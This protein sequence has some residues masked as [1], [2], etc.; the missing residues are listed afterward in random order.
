MKVFVTGGAGYIGSVCC[1]ELIN[2]GHSVVIFDNLSEGHRSAVDSR[3]EFIKGDLADRDLIFKAMHDARPDAVMHFAAHALVGESM[4]NP[5]KYF[6]NNVANGLNLID[7]MVD[8][9][10]KKIV[11]SSTCATYGFPDKIPIDERVHQK[12]INPYG[13]SKLIFEQILRWYD[14][15]HGIVHV[16]LRYFNAAGA[17]KNFGEDHRT[18]T[19]II[20]NVLKVALGQREVVEIYGDKYPT[21]DGT[22]IRDYIH[23]QDLA[24]AHMLALQRESSATYNLGTGEGFS[25]RQVVDVARKITG[26]P[27]P[28]IIKPPRPGD[29]HSLVASAHKVGKELGWKA[30][31]NRLTPI[32]ESAWL[33]HQS[34][35]QGYGD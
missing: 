21:P 3:A 20:P 2:S 26:C 23:I 30:R 17:S 32:V 22:C 11:F 7:A 14:Q 24:V 9:G 19:H 13:Q 4:T 31:F 10:V 27:I 16:N 25:V 5:S 29:P 8:V 33:W 15:L 12:P 34:H 18:E 1:E 28:T 6:R 35:P